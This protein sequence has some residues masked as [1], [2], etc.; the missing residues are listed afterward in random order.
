MF[1]AQ[2]LLGALMT[3]A[4]KEA[5]RSIPGLSNV[6]KAQVGLGAVGVALA[7]YEH[8]SQSSKAGV[9]TPSSIPGTPPSGPPPMAPPMGAPAQSQP[10]PSAEFLVRVMLSAAAADG[11][12]DEGE[13]AAILKPLREQGIAGDE[14]RF[15][16]EHFNRPMTP[17]AIAAEAHT[18][19]L[20]EQAFLVANLAIKVDTEAEALFLERLAMALQ[21]SP[22]QR[23]RWQRKPAS[24]P[25]PP[26]N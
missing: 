20:R 14:E 15:I 16:E 17:E 3:S 8:F 25:P 19:E 2:K 23:A 26:S 24:P 11:V 7:A 5:G 6:S 9:S 22:E 12:L 13:R 21:L 4:V 10:D 18:P 1:N